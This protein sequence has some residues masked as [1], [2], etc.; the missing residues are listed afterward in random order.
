MP[1][2][3]AG[4]HRREDIITARVGPQDVGFSNAVVWLFIVVLLLGLAVWA[5]TTYWL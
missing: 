4:Q 5:T 2:F 3:A 1:S